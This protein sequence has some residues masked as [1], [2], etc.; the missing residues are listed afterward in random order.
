MFSFGFNSYDFMGKRLE[1]VGW[2]WK[3]EDGVIVFLRFFRGC[4]KLG[5]GNI[6]GREID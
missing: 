3:L 2:K 6:C 4:F 1:E 5:G